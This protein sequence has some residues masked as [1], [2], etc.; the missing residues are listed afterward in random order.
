MLFLL[1]V[2]TLGGTRHTGIIYRTPR[3]I[4]LS[5]SCR[6]FSFPLRVSPSGP[7][8]AGV[9]IRNIESTP[10]TAYSIES[11]LLRSPFTKLAPSFLSSCAADD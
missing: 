10:F 9:P 11:K 3:A 7:S 5:I 2:I 8:P 1:G 6:Y 4:Y